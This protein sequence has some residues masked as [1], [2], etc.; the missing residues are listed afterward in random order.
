MSKSH[1]DENPY[2]N[3]RRKWNNRETANA[4]Y[5]IAWQL[6]AILCLMLCIASVGGLITV[7]QQSKFIPYIVEID[8]LG[9]VQEAMPLDKA[10]QVNDRIIGAT[11]ARFLENTRTV[12]PDV[13]LQR[14]AILRVYSHLNTGDPA[15]ALLNQHFNG[16][17]ERNPFARAETEVVSIEIN[18]IL[19]QSKESWQAEWTETVRDRKGKEIKQEHMR[20]LFTVYL[21]KSDSQDP[22][23]FRNNPLGI[24]VKDISWSSL[25]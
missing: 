17:P 16:S 6:L 14:R 8:K 21:T 5:R 10:A 13:E 24:F 15:S 2:L 22:A 3:A 4:R 11:L 19:R 7:A 1:N 9:R 12:T 25:R 18:S 23:K 20:A